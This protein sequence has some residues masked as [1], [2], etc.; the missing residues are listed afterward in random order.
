MNVRIRF[1]YRWMHSAH[2]HPPIL[3]EARNIN[4]LPF[5]ESHPFYVLSGALSDFLE[6]RHGDLDEAMHA[7]EKVDDGALDSFETGGEGFT[8]HITRSRVRFEHSVFGECPEWPIWCCTL[9]QYKAALEGYRR[10]LDMPKSL[11]SEL[12]IELPDGVPV[13]CQ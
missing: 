3:R 6:N 11:D 10:F 13:N 9:A 8:H 5:G 7:V 12:I 2:G 1:F 4:D